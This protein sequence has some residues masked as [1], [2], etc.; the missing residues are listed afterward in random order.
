MNKI[1]T[2][3]KVRHQKLG[4][5][6]VVVLPLEDYERLL[7]DLEMLRSKSF[8]ASIKRAREDVK[9]GRVYSL[10]EVRRRLKIR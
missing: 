5:V 2:I 1:A 3:E 4:K 7:E 9:R 8:A 6:P 10:A